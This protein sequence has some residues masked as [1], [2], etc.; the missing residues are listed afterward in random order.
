MP[1]PRPEACQAGDAVLAGGTWEDAGGAFDRAI[2]TR[3]SSDALEGLGVAEWWLDL[4]DVVIDSR[5]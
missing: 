3:A 2:A 4:A 1:E 5:A